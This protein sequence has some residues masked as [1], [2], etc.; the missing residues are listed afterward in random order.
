[1]V[2]IATSPFRSF[3]TT[4]HRALGRSSPPLAHPLPLSAISYANAILVISIIP[5]APGTRSKSSITR[6]QQIHPQISSTSP[7]SP[8]MMMMMIAQNNCHVVITASR[9]PI[10]L[11][12]NGIRDGYV[13]W[14]RLRV[15]LRIRLRIK[16]W[17]WICLRR[18][19]QRPVRWL[20]TGPVRRVPG[21]T[22]WVYRSVWV[23]EIWT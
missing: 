20:I 2:L 18:M 8:S 23:V 14:I 12:P 17:V 15:R 19:V 3:R 11:I 7:T 5:V 16:Q 1:M 22:E 4:S 21:R 6:S 10:V 13:L 9:V